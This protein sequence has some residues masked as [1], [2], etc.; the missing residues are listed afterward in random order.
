MGLSK[1][2]RWETPTGEKEAIHQGMIGV[3]IGGR[4]KK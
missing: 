2:H 3:N 1:R 4:C